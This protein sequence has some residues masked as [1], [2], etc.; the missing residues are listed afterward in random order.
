MSF[1]SHDALLNCLTAVGVLLLAF[2]VQAERGSFRYWLLRALCSATPHHQVQA[3]NKEENMQIRRM[4][5]EARTEHFKTL[6]RYGAAYVAI[7]LS[8]SM[9]SQEGNR[10]LGVLA[11]LLF[12]YSAGLFVAYANFQWTPIRITAITTL[13]NF[14]LLVRTCCIQDPGVWFLQSNSRAIFRLVT[15]VMDLD[16]RRVA[17]WN[18]AFFF[19]N[20]YKTVSMAESLPDLQR[21]TPKIWFLEVTLCVMLWTTSY[22]AQMWVAECARIACDASAS[23]IDKTMTDHLLSAF[24]DAQVKLGPNLELEGLHQKLSQILARSPAGSEV[25][26]GTSFLDYLV[27]AD[28]ARFK[29]FIDASA[30]PSGQCTSIASDD[31]Y[32][33]P[34]TL[35]SALHVHLRDSLGRYLPASIFHSRTMSAEQEAHHLIGICVDSPEE[36]TE[37][38]QSARD[39]A[40]RNSF[41]S[42]VPITHRRKSSSWSSR[43]SSSS[44]RSK[45]SSRLIDLPWIEK[46]SIT[47]DPLEWSICQVSW[48]VSEDDETVPKVDECMLQPDGR[49]FRQWVQEK[50]SMLLFPEDEEAHESCRSAMHG[51]LTLTLPNV[52]CRKP[53]TI[54]SKHA[55]L[56]LEDLSDAA[57]GEY[58]LVTLHLEGVHQ[59]ADEGRLASGMSTI[60]EE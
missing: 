28:R 26:Q 24:C 44:S 22:I 35:P 54:F 47:F 38:Q 59:I 8:I 51:S 25:F 27:V 4:F 56:D 29:A 37:A 15:A 48:N 31:V 40:K 17:L 53:I 60:G 42:H 43:S 3:K 45:R 23:R 18:I 55:W 21:P 39:S 5:D 49:K 58:T 50:V 9:L 10:Y 1:L 12:V 11:W 46:L 19:S 13:V 34:K 16:H 41:D 32:E 7:V 30:A 2:H 57:D 52:S 33:R 14:V 20:T 36:F 6:V